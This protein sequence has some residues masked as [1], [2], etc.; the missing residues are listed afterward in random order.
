[1]MDGDVLDAAPVD[2]DGLR[3][4]EYPEG[5]TVR[6]PGET[7]GRLTEVEARQVLSKHP[8]Y[9]ANWRH[10][11]AVGGEDTPRRAFLRWLEGADEHRPPARHEALRD[12]VAREWGQLSVG[13]RLIDGERRYSLRHVEDGDEPPDALDVLEPLDLRERVKHTD[14]DRYR[15]LKTAPTLP[16]GWVV[17]DL[18]GADAVR[19]IDFVYPATVPNWHREREGE[20]DVS[21]YRETAERQSGIYDVIDELDVESVE[22]LT[23]ACCVDSQCLKR[24][25]WDEDEE[26]DLDVPRGDGEFP[27]R[28]PCSLFIAAARKMTILESEDTREYTVELTPSEKA[29]L[30]DM[31]NAL[32][33]GRADEIREAD[34]NDGANRY[35]ARYLRAKRAEDGELQFNT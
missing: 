34:V 23:E 31:M 25:E 18:D 3:V 15:P 8:E 14:D 24:R 21:H 7:H 29:Q 10:W 16:T 33:D 1:M 32:A 9:V 17:D 4:H 19:A 2:C 22:Y 20:L 5:Y 13:V 6:V 35:R 27:C 30:D 12:G 11:R 26:T 28:E